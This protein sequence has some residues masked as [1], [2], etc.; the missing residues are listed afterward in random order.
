ML[1]WLFLASRSLVPI[2]TSLATIPVG[3]FGG[4]HADIRGPA[5][6]DMLS[7]MR[8]ITIEK[9][10]GP[11]WQQ[12]IVNSSQTPPIPCDAS[13]G[14]EAYQLA[15][16]EAV[17]QRNKAVAG[18]FYL[19]C[20]YDFPFY[21]LT[22]QFAAA[23]EHLRDIN[24]AVIGMEN[25]NGMKNVPVF[26]WSQPSAVKRY[27]DFHRNIVAQGLSDGTFPDKADVF[28]FVNT[29]TKKWNLCEAPGGPMHHQ[30]ADA[31]GEISDSKAKAYNSG[32]KTMLSG[33]QD[34]YGATGSLY[35]SNIPRH[36]PSLDS[37]DPVGLHAAVVETLKKS[38][39]LYFMLG[40]SN[41]NSTAV[42]KKCTDATI[43]SFLMVVE[44]GA[45][46][47]CNGWDER[48]GYPLGDP[49]TPPQLV[50]RVAADGS[51]DLGADRT[52]ERKFKSG[53]VV[54]FDPSTKKYTIDW[55]G[56]PPPPTPAPPLPTPSPS[57]PAYCGKV[58]TNTGIANDIHVQTTTAFAECC[59]LCHERK[60]CV[61]W[62]WHH[63]KN[64]LCHLH[65]ADARVS[66][67]VHRG[68]T[69]GFVN[70]TQPVGR[71]AFPAAARTPQ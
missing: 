69:S 70:G 2:N 21:N 60:G 66:P 24:G 59:T 14:E 67:D 16:L 43:A 30:W 54:R 58:M 53:T 13:C 7:K 71:A 8:L 1:A 15:T 20:L 36:S 45:V 18:A 50:T 40:D 11:C 10:E 62:S 34:I 17:K 5:S 35:Y 4:S 9:W 19:N 29:S 41:D 32:K 61:A 37:K 3:Y 6:L 57:L 25:D 46:L 23:D 47:G 56:H 63:E 65:G 48:F 52:V 33:L 26:D 22:G 27:L 44:K 42:T 12:C 51:S 28:A 55:A 64:N 49:L 31:C 39:Y 68:C 38:V